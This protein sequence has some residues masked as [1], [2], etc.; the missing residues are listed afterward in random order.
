MEYEF[1]GRSGLQVSR[2]CL[3]GMMFGGPTDAATSERIIARAF[4]A[5]VNVID[6]ADQYHAGQSERIIGT[7]IRANRHDWIVSTKL[8]NAMGTGPNMSGL[9]RKWIIQ[10]AEDSLRRLGTDF[11]D[12]YYLHR[13]DF[14]ASLEGIVSAMGDLI[15]SG[16]IRYFG[17][18]NHRAWRLA[19]ICN[20]CD[21][22]GVDRPVV[23]QPYYNAMNRMPEVE[24]L[25]ACHYYGL[26]VIPY[27]PLARGVLTG[28]YDPKAPPPADTR[29]GRRD[30]RMLEAEWREESLNIAGQVKENA[31]RAGATSIQFAVRW[32]L[33]NRLVTATIIGPRTEE[34]FEAYL[35]ALDY[36]FTRADE[37]LIDRLVIPGHPSTPG[38]NDPH[39]PIEGRVPRTGPT[40]DAAGHH[41]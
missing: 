34:Q 12:I 28:K 19:E 7:A 17:L 33:N 30:K 23:S 2:L 5:G 24:H 38:F 41:G 13:E 8:A 39:Y 27:S 31:A 6:T 25:P 11:I 26:G 35:S 4:D 15:A 1:L 18:S 14:N 29:A 40:A 22:M 32:V 20:L 3:G 10:A 36:E 21:R 16:K 9:S 37:E